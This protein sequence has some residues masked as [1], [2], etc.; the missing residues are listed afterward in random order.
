VAASNW[1][2]IVKAPKV[3]VNHLDG[4]LIITMTVKPTRR[5]RL[6]IWLA[7]VCFVIG[8]KIMPCDT[9]VSLLRQEP[10][11]CKVVG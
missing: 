3:N 2:K 7:R 1:R 4:K 8:A 5:F 11:E 6:R 9:E 10:G